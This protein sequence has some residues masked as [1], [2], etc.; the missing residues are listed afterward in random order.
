MKVLARLEYV[1]SFNF[2]DFS[3][4]E[5]C[6]YGKHVR[7]PH[8]RKLVQREREKLEL[9]HSDVCGPMPT[10]SLGG[11]SYFVTFIDDATRK[12]WVYPIRHKDDALKAFQKFLALAENE[13]GKKLK[14]LRTDNGGEYVGKVF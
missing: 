13:S 14:C 2:S 8:K 6:V 12:I 9:V 1:P 3:V 5:H 4:C 11:A 7:K 10:L